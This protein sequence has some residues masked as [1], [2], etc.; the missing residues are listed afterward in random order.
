MTKYAMCLCKREMKPDSEC[1]IKH[2]IGKDGTVYKRI[3]Y[4]NETCTYDGPAC[5]SDC[6]AGKGK[7]H[8][9][10]CDCEECPVCHGQL[11]SC[12]CITSW[13]D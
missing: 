7:V 4:G 12:D 13:Q 2:A 11:L 6:N 9:I 3:P 10:N 8:H 5:C 1:G